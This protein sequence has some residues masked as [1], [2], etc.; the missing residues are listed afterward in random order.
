MY[1]FLLC[2]SQ[3]ARSFPRRVVWIS[4]LF[5]RYVRD[6]FDFKISS[7]MPCNACNALAH[8]ASLHFASAACYDTFNFTYCATTSTFARPEARSFFSNDQ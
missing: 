5:K 8:F 2:I 6:A 7:C 4:P 1:S 3:H